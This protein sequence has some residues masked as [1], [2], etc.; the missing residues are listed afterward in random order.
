MARAATKG[1]SMRILVTGV[2]GFIGMHTAQLLL[3]RG[4]EGLGID[5][6][7]D[8]Y[9]VRLKQD[10][11]AQ[12]T[13][14]PQFSFEKLDIADTEAMRQYFARIKPQ[15]VVH[16]AAQAGVRYSLKNPHAYAQS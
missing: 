15:R 12:L 8:Y 10:R 4:D 7:N 11:L 16:L 5:N 6:L 13:P 14:H 2:A 9:D 3:A 1:F